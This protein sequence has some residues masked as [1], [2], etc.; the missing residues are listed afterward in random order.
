MTLNRRD[1]LKGT[2]GALAAAGLLSQTTAAQADWEDEL[3]RTIPDPEDVPLARSE[4]GV[5]ATSHP[6][7]TEAAIEILEDGG[8][9][10]DAAVAAQLALSVVEPNGTGLSGEAVMQAYVAEEDVTYVVNGMERA[11]GAAEPDMFLDDDGNYLGRREIYD[12]GLAHG[13]PGSIRLDDTALKRWGTKYFDE[14]TQPAI[15]LAE[16]GWEL[17]R[18]LSLRIHQTQ[19]TLNEAARDVYLDDDGEPLQPGDLLVQADLGKSLRLIAEGGSEVFYH[20]E[21]AEAAT[22]FIQDLGGV[23]TLDDYRRYQVSV[24]HPVWFEYDG[25]QV[26]SEYNVGL[27]LRLLE[28]FDLDA[29]DPRDPDRYHLLLEAMDLANSDVGAHL[30]DTDFVDV[31]TQGL[32]SDSYTTERR[33]LIDFDEVSSAGAGDPWAHQPGDAYQ[34]D[35]HVPQ[36]REPRTNH[37]VV[38]D[39]EGNVVGLTST[40]GVGWVAGNMVPGYGFMLSVIQSYFPLSGSN[41]IEPNKRE[42]AGAL[43]MTPTFVYEDGVPIASFDSPGALYSAPLQVLVN[44]FEHDMGLAE[45]IAEPRVQGASW[46]DGVTEEVRE[47]LEAKGHGFASDWS[48]IGSVQAIVRDRRGRGRDVWTAAADPRRDGDAGAVDDGRGPPG[49]GT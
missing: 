34:T 38:A 37:L 12:R 14:V 15:E 2:A 3:A 28:G 1:V 39:D 18:E 45:A 49:R 46:E 26:S 17:D 16:E 35:G 43:A 10:F 31:P 30:A 21:I 42:V 29:L 33:S 24:D 47:A 27:A 32:L 7:A 19:D 13:V 36:T 23:T 40:L 9:A 20:G 44:V 5:A 41:A 6:L 11:A 22:E 8:N 4:G 48:D 25:Y